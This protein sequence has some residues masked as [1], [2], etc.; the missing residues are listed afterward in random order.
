MSF[1]LHVEHAAALI[2]DFLSKRG[3][4]AHFQGLTELCKSR[5][6]YTFFYGIDPETK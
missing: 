2:T 1:R 3:V 6:K 4:M 5:F